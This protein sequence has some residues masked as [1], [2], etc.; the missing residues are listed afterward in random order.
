MPSEPLPDWIVGYMA[1]RD[2]ERSDR[3]GAT[4]AAMTDRERLLVREVAVMAFVRGRIF[5][6]STPRDEPHP[7]DSEVVYE[8]VACAQSPSMADH[9][10]VL[11]ET[12]GGGST[13]A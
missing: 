9:Y 6:Q 7:K 11:S 12:L 2:A 1:E 13:S 4:L 5:G 3:V 8:V 10:P